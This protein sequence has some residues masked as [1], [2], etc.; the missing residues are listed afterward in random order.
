MFSRPAINT[1][2]ML[3]MRYMSPVVPL[4]LVINDY[5]SYMSIEV[6]KRKALKQEL[7]FPVV[8]LGEKQKASWVVNLSD[9]AN[10][11]DKQTVLAQ[12]DHRAMQGQ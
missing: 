1:F 2:S 8:R 9:L 11:I 3:C 4:D 5:L 10:Y 6:A 7:P 12:Q